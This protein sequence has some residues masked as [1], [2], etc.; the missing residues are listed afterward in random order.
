MRV[1]ISI[2]PIAVKLSMK[3]A[4][5]VGFRSTLEAAMGVLASN[6]GKM[7]CDLGMEAF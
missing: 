2:Y 7:Y 6:C 4:K 5:T 1:V 3:E